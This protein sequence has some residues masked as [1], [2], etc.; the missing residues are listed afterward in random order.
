MPS[1][2]GPLPPLKSE[3]PVT[4]RTSPP[5]PQHCVRNMRT[6]FWM[7]CVFRTRQV[8]LRLCLIVNH[9]IHVF[10]QLTSGHQHEDAHSVPSPLQISKDNLE[11]YVNASEELGLFFSI[12]VP[13][14]VVAIWADINTGVQAHFSGSSLTLP[15][16]PTP[17]VIP[18]F[19]KM[20]WVPL[21]P[22]LKSKQHH[23]MARDIKLQGP[24]FTLE[25]LKAS[26]KSCPS[27][28]SRTVPWIIIC[29]SLIISY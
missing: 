28:R 26:T 2:Q 8:T 14:I 6:L 7:F 1:A 24:H 18:S 10:K 23:I 11:S 9:L 3:N 17:E 5:Q 12:T 20:D 4:L 27:T 22:S 25:Q 15:P 13:N 29:M 21:R 16:C 19:G